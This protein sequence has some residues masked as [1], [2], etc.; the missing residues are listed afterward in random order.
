MMEGIDKSILMGAVQFLVY[1]GLLTFYLLKC[2]GGAGWTSKLSVR[3]TAVFAGLKALG[4]FAAAFLNIAWKT[5][6]LRQTEETYRTLATFPDTVIGAVTGVY[7]FAMLL[8][9]FIYLG[10]VPGRKKK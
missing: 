1:A 10:K 8:L 3:V 4:A 9:A 5:D 2:K 7:L 6:L